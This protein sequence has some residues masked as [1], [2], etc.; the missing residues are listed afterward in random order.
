[1]SA[2]VVPARISSTSLCPRARPRGEFVVTGEV[3]DDSRVWPLR[4]TPA[5]V[6][7]APHVHIAQHPVDQVTVA[8][9]QVATNQFTVLNSGNTPLDVAFRVRPDPGLRAT[10]EPTSLSIAPGASG[11]VEL[12]AQPLTEVKT[13]YET[14]V[15]VSVEARR[16]EYLQRETVQLRRRFCPDPSRF[17]P[18]VR[19]VRRRGD[20]RRARRR[21]FR[22]EPRLR[23]THFA[24]R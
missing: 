8:S 17:R 3:R 19:A 7:R 9:D 6:R 10:I 4:A 1:M 13:L 2:A 24:R 22:R 12:T 23:G 18:A 20:P 15:A 5:R 14:A 21:Q 11:A 16:E